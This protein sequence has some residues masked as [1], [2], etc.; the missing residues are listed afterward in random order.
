MT[1][2]EVMSKHGASPILHMDFMS[3][4]E[5]TERNILEIHVRAG[6][7]REQRMKPQMN[8]DEQAREPR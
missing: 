7:R 8:T 4:D 2:V 5:I 1:E 3:P 6:R